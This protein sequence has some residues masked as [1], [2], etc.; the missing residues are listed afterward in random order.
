M[1]RPWA[2]LDDLRAG[3]AARPAGG[4]AFAHARPEAAVD[5]SPVAGP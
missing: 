2:R 4:R 5:T 3:E 1:S